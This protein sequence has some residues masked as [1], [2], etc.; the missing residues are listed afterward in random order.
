LF[1]AVSRNYLSES[2]K[3]PIKS[4]KMRKLEESV[5]ALMV[6]SINNYQYFLFMIIEIHFFQKRIGSLSWDMISKIP[7]GGF[8]I[9]KEE[10][11]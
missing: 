9:G 4:I 8:Y 3:E 5:V 6:L 7:E 1:N 10:E 11:F 2:K